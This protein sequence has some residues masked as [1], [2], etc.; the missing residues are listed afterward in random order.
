MDVCEDEIRRE[1]SRRVAINH[2]LGVVAAHLDRETFHTVHTN[3]FEARTPVD[4]RYS[5]LPCAAEPWIASFALQKSA[6]SL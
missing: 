5:A 3:A 4:C 6:L 1:R 2:T